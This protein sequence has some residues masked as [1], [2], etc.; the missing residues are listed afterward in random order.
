[1]IGDSA[2]DDITPSPHTATGLDE[3]KNEPGSADQSEEEAEDG[4]RGW[5]SEAERERIT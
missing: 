2:A 5:A 4:V 3:S 1:M